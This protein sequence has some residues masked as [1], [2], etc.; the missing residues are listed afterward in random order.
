MVNKDLKCTYPCFDINKDMIC[1]QILKYIKEN[2]LTDRLG[3]G[4]KHHEIYLSDP[5]KSKPETMKTVLR[6]P[7]ERF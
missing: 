7:V 3:K 5:R 6:H 1:P 4:G 2:G